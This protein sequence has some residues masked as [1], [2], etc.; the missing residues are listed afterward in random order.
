MN[1]LKKNSDL[2]GWGIQKKFDKPGQ[3]YGHNF[4]LKYLECNN[5]CNKKTV[6]ALKYFIKRVKLSLSNLY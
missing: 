5:I 6:L 1:F 3:M 2:M 4:P